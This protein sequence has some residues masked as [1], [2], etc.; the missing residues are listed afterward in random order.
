MKRSRNSKVLGLAIGEQSLL[1]AEVAAGERPEVRRL[2]EFSY[3]QGV[4]PSDP[5]TLGKA[6]GQFLHDN[7]FTARAAV[8]GLPARWLL[9]K[10]KDVPPADA[11]TL[12]DLL[13]LQ[14]EGEFST[15]LRDLVYEYAGDPAATG[16]RSVLLLATQR[17]HVEA[18]RAMGDAANVDVLAVTPSAVVLGA[19]TASAMGGDPMVLAIGQSGSELTAQAGPFPTAIR[20]LRSAGQEKAFI[21]EL[22]RAISS[23]P[24]N[25]KRHELVV[26]DGG[27]LPAGSL[28]ESLGLPVRQA[29]LP[30]LGVVA[31]ETGNGDGRNYAAAVALALC[32]VGA[33]EMPVDFLH[34]R[35]APPKAQRIPRGA[36]AAVL[37]AIVLIAGAA[38]GYNDLQNQQKSLDTYKH[39]LDDMKGEIAAASAFVSKV[40]FA[41]GWHGGNPRYLACLRDLTLAIPEDGQTYATSLVIREN[42]RPPGSGAASGTQ[43]K[44]GEAGTLT[45]SLYAKT[46]DQ[47]RAQAVL[48]RLKRVPAFTD[49]KSGGTQSAGRGPEVT[50]SITFTYLPPRTA[51]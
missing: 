38:Y 31:P 33:G 8:V 1:V 4:S 21:G 29:D 26:W 13:R 32:G 16:S 46:L 3:P 14:A 9:V 7:H 28:N 24:S 50:F 34:S 30:A 48:D 18:A 6:L 19:S 41:Q 12:A 23:A 37:L 44:Q 17:K 10:P 51:P 27:G 39:R 2:A 25:G 42:V 5:V 15:E 40:S 45:G 43:T 20:Y 22:R 35:L 36:A 11:A 47:Q 49:V